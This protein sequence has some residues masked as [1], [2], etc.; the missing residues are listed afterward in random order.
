M[1]PPT[2]SAFADG[3]AAAAPSST[4]TIAA[5]PST[6]LATSTSSPLRDRRVSA[7]TRDDVRPGVPCDLTLTVAVLGASGDLAK[8]KTFPALFTLFHKGCESVFFSFSFFLFSQ[9][10]EKRERDGCGGSFALAGRFSSDPF[11][12][13]P[14]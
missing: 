14:P 2:K 6:S 10:R 12:R 9:E 13:P 8:K 5:S 4:A 11:P 7:S 3:A 1:S